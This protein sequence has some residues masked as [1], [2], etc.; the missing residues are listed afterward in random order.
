[1]G[2]Y[3]FQGTGIYMTFLCCLPEQAEENLQ[4]IWEV[5]REAEQ[6]GITEDELRRAKSKVCSHIVVHSERPSNR[7]FSV[8]SNWLLR[9]EYRTVREMVDAYARVTVQ[10]IRNVLDQFPLT[11]RP[12]VAVGPLAE[13]RFSE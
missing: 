10:D 7:L 11:T 3:E 4:R 13:L 1:M 2:S 6:N 9:R 5:Q 8:G 12:T